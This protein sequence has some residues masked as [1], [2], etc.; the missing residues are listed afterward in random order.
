MPVAVC[1]RLDGV[2]KVDIVRLVL[3]DLAVFVTGLL[4]Y[5]ICY[6]LLPPEPDHSEELPTTVR[7]HSH[8]TLDSILNFFG[9]FLVVLFLAASGIIVPSAIS[10]F[11]FLSF[12]LIATIWA[13]YGRLGSKFA[14]FRAILLIYC[15]GHILLLHSSSERPSVRP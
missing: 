1:C 13:F 3:P 12:I 5:I 8:G 10:A 2:P 4:V 14:V 7:K 15:G 11:Y 9:E 6:K